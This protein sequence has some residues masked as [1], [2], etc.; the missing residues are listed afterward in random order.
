MENN[1]QPFVEEE[2]DM[3]LADLLKICYVHFKM[4]W[5]WFVVSVVLCLIA[6]YVYLQRQPRVYQSQ[7][8]MLIEDADPSGMGGMNSRSRNNMNSLLELNGISVGDNL[9]NEMFVLTS[10]RL[11][12]RVVDS[13]DLN[14]EYSIPQSLHSVSLYRSTPVLAEFSDSV[15]MNVSF[16]VK[17]LDANKYQLKDLKVVYKGA[18]EPVEYDTK[19]TGEFG[20]P[21]ATAVGE[22]CLA[23]QESFESLQ[24]EDGQFKELELKVSRTSVESATLAYRARLTATEYDKESSLIVLTCRDNNVGRANDV[25]NEVYMAY[26][27]DAVEYKNRVAQNTADFIDKRIELISKELNTVEDSY[28][29]F[30]EKNNLVDLKLDASSYLTENT[31]ARKQMLELET[32]LA[33]TKYLTDYV[34]QNSG[35]DQPIPVLGGLGA[36]GTALTASITEYNKLVLELVRR[37]ENSS[38]D[39]P[40][41]REI[42]RR[43]EALYTTIKAGLESNV[44]AIELKLED[45]HRLQAKVNR[46]TNQL[47]EKQRQAIDIE[48]QKALKEAL[49]TYLLNKREEVALQLAIEE[50]NVRLVEEPM[51]TGAPVSPRGKMIVL[52]SIVLG[53]LIPAAVI[54]IKEMFNT[55]VQRRYDV[56]K[57]TNVPIVGELP[58]WE[59]YQD[60]Q[61]IA[62]AK[63][64]D[65]VSE[66]FRVLRHQLDFFRHNAK[67]F[68]VTSS[69]PHQ[70][71]SF[72]SKNLSTVLGMA[73]NKDMEFNKVLLIDA[74]IRKRSISRA[75]SN[76]KRRGLT[77]YL[78]EEP[79]TKSLAE[80]VEKDTIYKGVDFLPGGI[81]PPNPSE[82]LM[83][84]RLEEL[85]EE[86]KQKY[87]YIIIDTTPMLSVADAS[88]VDRVADVTLFVVRMGVEEVSFLPQLDKLNRD[89]KLRN[90]ALVLNDIDLRRSYGYGYGYGYSYGYGYGFDHDKKKK[91]GLFGKKK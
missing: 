65:P 25:I 32:E 62:D 57:A 34:V 48:R 56:E 89:K 50:A 61:T 66:S 39:A 85:I 4:N 83:S 24:G 1:K 29:S 8:V 49:Y 45:A 68:V 74:D 59:G 44:K 63:P 81:M 10:R 87:D 58:E 11:M 70:G 72:V 22:I 38:M 76:T 3:Q 69:T 67:V 37:S 13:L 77:S 53:L 19:Y 52:V 21:L 23:K 51:G 60:S 54:F 47:P 88:I 91:K 31:A 75:L 90:M 5:V 20:T 40:R 30:M 14:V 55:T 6:G 18:K 9:K 84:T 42:S 36:A 26:K 33:V 2:N 64:D 80:Y 7:A 16:E 86:A 28:E 12:Q 46:Q 15:P 43:I 82:L 41:M 73:Y 71:K 17:I 79:G 27:R 35:N 78:V